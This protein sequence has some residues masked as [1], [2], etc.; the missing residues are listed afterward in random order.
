MLQIVHFG[1]EHNFSFMNGKN[2]S[3]FRQRNDN[4][5]IHEIERRM[6]VLYEMYLCVFMCIITSI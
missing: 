6:I 2:F 4:N 5:A 3:L 1:E